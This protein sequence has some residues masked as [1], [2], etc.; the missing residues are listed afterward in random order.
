[1]ADSSPVIAMDGPSGVGKGTICLRVAS[2]LGWNILDSGSLYRLVALAASRLD[3]LNDVSQLVEIAKKLEVNHLTDEG[4]L[5]IFLK[6]EEVTDLIRSEEIGVVAS[7][8]AAIPELRQ[9]L[10][11]RQKACARAP[12]LVADGR[13]MGTVVF[14]EAKLKIFFTASQDVRAKRRYK[15]LKDKG[16]DANLPQL[17]MELKQR[18]ERDSSRSVSP[19]VAASD[20]VTIDTTSLNIEEVFSEVMKEVNRRFE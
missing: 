15:Q 5:K 18:D 10:L 20:A 2:E 9:A 17:V 19:L 4:E 1:M 16:I 6:N 12:G 7:K 8:I 11:V 13:D 14:P 3:V